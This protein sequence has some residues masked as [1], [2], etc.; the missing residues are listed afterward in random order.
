MMRQNRQSFMTPSTVR[1]LESRRAAM[2][3]SPGRGRRVPTIPD[4]RKFCSAGSGSS[5]SIYE[6]LIQIWRAFSGLLV[7][8]NQENRTLRSLSVVSNLFGPLAIVILHADSHPPVAD[9]AAETLHLRSL[10]TV[11]KMI[12]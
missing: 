12:G 9:R 6:H 10:I 2:R 11:R 3:R 1:N 5:E 4:Q 7:E 8:S